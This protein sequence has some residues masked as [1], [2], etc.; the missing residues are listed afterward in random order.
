VHELQVPAIPIE[1]GIDRGDLCPQRGDAQ[2]L[3]HRAAG[4]R[5]A[6]RFEPL[7]RTSASALAARRNAA[8]PV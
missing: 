6:R 2:G 3:H 4:D 1:E 7:P 5:R 8:P